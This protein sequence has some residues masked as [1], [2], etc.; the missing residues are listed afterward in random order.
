MTRDRPSHNQRV[1]QIHPTAPRETW[2]DCQPVITV[3]TT[4][5]VLIC[6]GIGVAEFYGA[7]AIAVRDLVVITV[8][9]LGVLLP[10][11]WVL[12]RMTYS[13]RELWNAL[14]PPDPDANSASE[15]GR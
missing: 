6:G 4:A 1:G 15:P 7:L 2:L 5:A 14:H 10:A 12:Q 8:W 9:T 11:A 3:M 13:N